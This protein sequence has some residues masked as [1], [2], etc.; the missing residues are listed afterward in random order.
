MKILNLVLLTP[1]LYLLVRLF[2]FEDVNDPIKYIYTLTG[3]SA[4]VILFISITFSIIKEKINLIKYRKIVGLYG[5]FY[6]LLH[7][8]NFIGF[9]AQFDVLFIFEETIDKPFI[10]LGMIAFF[11]VLFMAL[12]SSKILFRKFNKF[13]K[14]IYIALVLII[15]HWLM[16]QK[17][18]E[19]TSYLYLALCIV[20]LMLRL[21]KLSIKSNH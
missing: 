9:D 21:N 13:H 12:T 6:A 4:T 18:L 16:A 15:I 2:I 17:S 20:V 7:L 14:L 5:F 19:F 3:V 8:L 10:Y 1:L 11:I